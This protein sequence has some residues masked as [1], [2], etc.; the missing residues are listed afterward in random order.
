MHLKILRFIFSLSLIFLFSYLIF[1]ENKW[2]TIFASITVEETD[3]HENDGI[4]NTT[5]Q[6][7]NNT[8]FQKL[9]LGELNQLAS[10]CS[11]DQSFDPTTNQC[12]PISGPCL[13]GEVRGEKGFCAPLP[14]HCPTRTSIDEDPVCEP[15]WLNTKIPLHQKLQQELQGIDGATTSK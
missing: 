7:I 12:D 5:N 11:A 9:F 10:K 6:Q 8:A 4:K 3:R 13:N 2:P 15:L 1:N 14:V